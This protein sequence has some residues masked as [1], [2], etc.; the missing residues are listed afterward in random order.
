MPRLGS[1]LGSILA[2][3]ARARLVADSLS[4]D[5]VDE[6]RSDPIL[7]SMSVP[8]IQID[9]AELTLR[10]T[11]ADLQEAAVAGPAVEGATAGWVRHVA[12]SVVPSILDAHDL[13]PEERSST[14]AHLVGSRRAPTISVPPSAM[15]EALAGNPAE[16][17]KVTTEAVLATW[18]ELPADVRTKLGTKAEF[19]REVE[20]RLSQEVPAFVGRAGELE[21]VRAALASKIDVGIRS[22]ELPT[23]PDRVQELRLTLRG[24]DVSLILD[25]GKEG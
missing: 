14:L 23:Q 4:R 17:S 11:V 3:L 9:R 8:R 20:A 6:Y 12:S 5:L 2:E 24:E 21:L 10:F 16:S 15:R 13:N 18:A 1:V 22:D 25:A 19:R 7:A